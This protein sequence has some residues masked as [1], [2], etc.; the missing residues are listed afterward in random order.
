LKLR[1]NELSLFI[2]IKEWYNRKSDKSVH[3]FVDTPGHQSARTK[4]YAR[5][6]FWGFYPIELKLCIILEPII[7]ITSY[8]SCFSDYNGFWWEISLTQLTGEFTFL[9]F[10]NGPKIVTKWRR[11]QISKLNIFRRIEHFQYFFRILLCLNEFFH[12]HVIFDL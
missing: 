11:I 7:P 12:N 9:N 10:A 1:G 6:N 8:R 5:K 4:F 2:L 3:D